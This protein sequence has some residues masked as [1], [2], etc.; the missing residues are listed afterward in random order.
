MTAQQ[1]LR[2]RCVKSLHAMQTTAWA[3]YRMNHINFPFPL[4]NDLVLT[5]NRKIKDILIALKKAFCCITLRCRRKCQ[6]RNLTELC[7][8]L[9]S[10]SSPT[11]T[12]AMCYSTQTVNSLEQCDV[13]SYWMPLEYLFSEKWQTIT[14]NKL[15][16]SQEDTNARAVWFS[17]VS[18][19][20]LILVS[21]W[22]AG[23]CHIKDSIIYL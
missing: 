8:D 23:Q 11:H 6:S 12:S 7:Y 21:T 13:C 5:V 18:S 19:V 2:R 14:L 3:L 22:K 10:V 17:I 9:N 20:S 16:F 15:Q 1:T 4:I